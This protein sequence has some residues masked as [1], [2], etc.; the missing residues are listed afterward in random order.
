MLHS[1]IIHYLSLIAV[2]SLAQYTS[3]QPKHVA[4]EQ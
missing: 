4:A 1:K 3:L 2:L